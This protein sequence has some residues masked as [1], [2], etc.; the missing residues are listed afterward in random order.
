VPSPLRLYTGLPTQRP[1]PPPFFSPLAPLGLEITEELRRNNTYD[2][3]LKPRLL[4]LVSSR[5]PDDDTGFVVGRRA[6]KERHPNS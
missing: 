6:K 1:P 4:T 2:R 3:K 5:S